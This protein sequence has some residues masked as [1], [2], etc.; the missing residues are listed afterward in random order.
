MIMPLVGSDK[1]RRRGGQTPFSGGRLLT[2][3]CWRIEPAQ[4]RAPPSLQLSSLSPRTGAG[5]LVGLSTITRTV[6][7]A[8]FAEATY[9]WAVSTPSPL[10]SLFISL[11]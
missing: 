7:F 1:P 5:L 8:T 6:V 9:H 3:L 11:F 4:L 10:R 2:C